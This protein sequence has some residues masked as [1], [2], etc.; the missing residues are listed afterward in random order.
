MSAPVFI[1]D[2]WQYLEFEKLALGAYAPL[3]GFM[4]G[5]A[6]DA[7]VETLHLPDGA[8]FPLPIVLEM[9]GEE[10]RRLGRA[11]K[12]ELRFRDRSVG[13]LFPEDV[14]FRDKRP[15]AGKVFGVDDP[16]HPGVRQFLRGEGHF[17]GGRVELV[18][19]A[20][21][22]FSA[23]EGT[24]AATRAVFQARG[25]RTVAGFQT[26]N[27]P[28]KAHEYLLRL[29]LEMVDGLFIHPLVG[30]KKRGDYAPEA[31][32]TSY[33][34]LIADFLP[35]DRVHLG[36]LS[37]AMRYA[38]PREAVFH[39]LVRRNY[40]CTHF[41]VGRDH[42][43]VGGYY[44]TYASQRL[45]Q[46]LEPELGIAILP[47]AGPFYC[48]RCGMIATERTCPHRRTDPGSVHE[49]SGTLIR[50]TLVEGL[51]CDPRFIRPE[52]VQGLRGRTI[53]I[54]QDEHE[55]N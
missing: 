15:A 21:F 25:W 18:E 4:T 10:A 29:A 52:I 3:H 46:A 43:G 39:A 9:S 11:G 27:V 34:Q 6:F 53:F 2:P 13:W 55:S 5:A 7:V 26:R 42:A 19:R 22:A 28:H 17:V 47:F 8:V 33:Q 30:W 12:V 23:F 16:A 24:P 36:V 48:E 45:A 51:A 40:G 20:S 35:S 14:F 32:L 54:E 31:V 1:L 44:D 37:A 50:G 49:I 38:G 41:I